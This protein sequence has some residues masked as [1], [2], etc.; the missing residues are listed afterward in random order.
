MEIRGSRTKSDEAMDPTSRLCVVRKTTPI[1]MRM[2][3]IDFPAQVEATASNKW[4]QDKDD[5]GEGC[6]APQ[7]Q[8]GV[9]PSS[10]AVLVGRMFPIEDTGRSAIFRLFSTRFHRVGTASGVLLEGDVRGL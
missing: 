8:D 4:C 10:T 9:P 3:S 2:Q 6:V 1:H 7:E 5:E